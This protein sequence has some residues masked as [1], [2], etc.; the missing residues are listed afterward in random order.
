VL[1][2]VQLV[3]TCSGE[4]KPWGGLQPM[5]AVLQ[6]DTK[7]DEV[8][9]NMKMGDGLKIMVDA[10]G[11]WPE[12]YL[13]G[14]K[15][16]LGYAL[17][18][19]AS[20]AEATV[21]KSPRQQIASAKD[22]ES[23][24]ALTAKVETVEAA[25]GV[26]SLSPRLAE[27]VAK[28]ERE[29]ADSQRAYEAL[30]GHPLVVAEGAWSQ[31]KAVDQIDAFTKAFVALSRRYSLA[32]ATFSVRGP[33]SSMRFYDRGYNLEIEAELLACGAGAMAKYPLGELGQRM[34]L[35]FLA[36]EHYI[37]VQGFQSVLGYP[38]PKLLTLRLRNASGQRLTFRIF[39]DM[40]F[41]AWSG[42]TD[43]LSMG[44]SYVP[45]DLVGLWD[46]FFAD[47]RACP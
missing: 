17:D 28:R 22:V 12:P 42:T 37:W 23:W 10:L 34:G 16:F 14:R 8:D 27:A 40:T 29:I 31:G 15:Q 41:S 7:I 47:L 24:K 44:E 46:G 20:R 45:P 21:F 9:S 6:A 26:A 33:D 2:D 3:L 13:D 5:V 43:V 36:R 38:T 19:V 4:S 1:E 11:V 30:V 25:L 32:N 18:Q 39:E 35:P